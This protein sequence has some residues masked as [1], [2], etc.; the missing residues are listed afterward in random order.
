MV[1]VP[2]PPEPTPTAKAPE[3]VPVSVAIS[4]THRFFVAESSFVLPTLDTKSVRAQLSPATSTKFDGVV[5]ASDAL[6]AANAAELQALH[7]FEMCTVRDDP[8]PQGCRALEAKESAA[9][10]TAQAKRDAFDKQTATLSS[11]LDDSP[12]GALG[13][14]W[15]DDVISAN[16]DFERVSGTPF[17]AS[18]ELG[19][20]AGSDLSNTWGEDLVAK[21]PAS[22][23]LGVVVRIRAAVSALSATNPD[24]AIGFLEEARTVAAGT[25][26]TDIWFL[27][28][29]AH[30]RRAADAK[31]TERD[32]EEALKSAESP[33]VG[34]EDIGKAL[35]LAAYRASDFPRALA[36]ALDVQAGRLEPARSANTGALASLGVLASLN[37]SFDGT[38]RDLLELEVGSIERIGE[39]KADLSKADAR[40]VG[41]IAD[42]LALRA[43]YV[44]DTEHA[45]SLVRAHAED[46]KQ[47][48]SLE[49]AVAALCERHIETPHFACPERAEPPARHTGDVPL[50]IDEEV[51]AGASKTDPADERQIAELTRLCA[52]PELV[53]FLSQPSV[54]H[55]KKKEEAPAMR[56][57]VEIAR[58]NVQA[59]VDSAVPE[60]ADALASIAQCLK[61]TAP[62]RFATSDHRITATIDLT[63]LGEKASFL[64][65]E[66]AFGDS[67]LENALGGLSGVAGP[68]TSSAG[69]GGGGSAGL[70]LGGG[71]TIGHG[72]GGAPPPK[73][74]PKKKP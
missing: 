12:G 62:Q 41:R 33:H 16:A 9:S 22:D 42:E 48:T 36:V 37:F 19:E 24:A 15:L 23:P 21:V 72:A 10:T 44:G 30:G 6:A 60:R 3:L 34:R 27:L 59:T 5:R 64:G 74:H 69:R 50:T 43:L 58:T 55:Q 52:E 68:A 13:S 61:A 40:E 8:P 56:I 1:N 51:R 73:P 25:D 2:A 67:A 18:F 26:L 4:E 71:G 14:A 32:F 31:E 7:A 49:P 11:A 46:S 20:S 28:G 54:R 29:Q 45:A 57:V 17:N 47:R 63:R 38:T 65:G 66:S 53:R 35:A 39:D 70:M